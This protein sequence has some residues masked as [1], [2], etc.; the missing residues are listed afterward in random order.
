M[1]ALKT[2]IIDEN[3]D[4]LS[5]CK[6][7]LMANSDIQVEFSNEITVLEALYLVLPDVVVMGLSINEQRKSQLLKLIN[8]RWPTCK[9]LV[10]VDN[11]SSTEVVSHL[12]ASAVGFIHLEDTE[13]FLIK[14]VTK[15][16]EGE[17]W[18]PRKLVSSL[19]ERFKVVAA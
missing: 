1:S 17:A 18:V 19:V 8:L 16:N 11:Q 12:E 10:V 2:L 6:G 15:I 9:V 3:S 5:L 13:Q 14:A 4:F 7:A